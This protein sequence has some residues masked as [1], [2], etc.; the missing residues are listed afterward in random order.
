[1][2]TPNENIEITLSTELL[3]VAKA[4]RKDDEVN[5]NGVFERAV[6]TQAWVEEK[7]AAG[8]RVVAATATDSDEG[9]V[10]SDYEYLSPEPTF[11]AVA[12]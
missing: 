9:R 1:M 7:Q 5:F 10:W 2:S 4:L 12:E 11:E 8:K 6:T 3:N